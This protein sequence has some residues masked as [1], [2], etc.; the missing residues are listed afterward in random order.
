M[1]Y[2]CKHLTTASSAD[3]FPD[4]PSL[5]LSRPASQQKSS[6][7]LSGQRAPSSGTTIGHDPGGPATSVDA[8]YAKERAPLMGNAVTMVGL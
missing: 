4:K 2:G 8:I 6:S 3:S 1:L 7:G 5:S